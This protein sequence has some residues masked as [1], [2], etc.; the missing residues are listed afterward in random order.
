[1][2]RYGR[3]QS[4]RRARVRKM[5]QSSNQSLTCV[6]VRSW[7]RTSSLSDDALS[8]SGDHLYRSNIRARRFARRTWIVEELAREAAEGASLA[9]GGIP[10]APIGSRGYARVAR[11]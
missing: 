6:I 4:R 1:M 2:L 3:F 9:D 7:T 11:V 10:P 5:N 8:D